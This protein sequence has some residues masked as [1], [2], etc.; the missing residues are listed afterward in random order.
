MKIGVISDTHLDNFSEHLGERILKHFK[1]VDMILHAG[2]VVELSVL[3]FF[4]DK[5]VKL[6]AG[7]M[8]SWEI[9]QS[10]PIKQVIQIEGYKLGLI[11]GWGS[12]VGI[13][14]R[15]LKEFDDIDILVYGH[16]HNAASFTKSGVQFFNPGSPTDKRFATKNTIGILNIGNQISSQII[17]I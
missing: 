8:D 3:D 13:E 1:D 9:K 2:D 17:T 5:E 14:D 4:A 16:T 6:V 7:N 10:A 11:H 12:P 15:I